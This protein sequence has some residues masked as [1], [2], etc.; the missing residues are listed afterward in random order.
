LGKDLVALRDVIFESTQQRVP[1]FKHYHNILQRPIIR[2][3]LQTRASTYSQVKDLPEF[4]SR[5][6]GMSRS[7]AL[8]EQEGEF[9]EQI[10]R[11]LSHY[12]GI[13]F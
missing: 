7:F 10:D 11:L 8:P 1:G 9:A 6:I 5:I 13:P 12:N 2:Q 4:Q 3:I